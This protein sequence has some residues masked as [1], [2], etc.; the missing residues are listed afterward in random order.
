MF[1]FKL[2]LSL[3]LVAFFVVWTRLFYWQV[4]SSANLRALAEAQH[5]FRL[6]IPARQGKI[7]ATDGM[8][9]ATNQPAYLVFAEKN[10]ITDLPLFIE[11]LAQTLDVDTASLSAKFTGNNLWVP[12]Q[13][14]TEEETVRKL[15][16]LNLKGLDFERD[17]KRY[18]PEA[19]MSAHLLGFVGKDELGHDKGYFGVEGYYEKELR[20]EVGYLRQERDARGAPIVIGENERVEPENGRDL[21]LY[22]DKTIQFIAEDKLQKALTRYGAKSGNVVIM[23]P[24]TGGILASASY[25]S[26]DPAS[27]WQFPSEYYRNPVIAESYEPGSTFKVLVMAKAL[28]EGAVKPHDVYNENGPVEIGEYSI[29]TWNN[30]YHGEISMTE[31]LEYSS[32]VG[33]VDVARKLGREK[34]LQG[35]RDFGFGD[36]TGIDLQEESAPA[37]RDAKEMY[38]IDWATLSFGQGIA[39]TPIQMLRAVAAIAN[40][41]LL[42]QPQVVKRINA[43]GKVVEITPKKIRRVIKSA[44]AKVV[45]EMMVAAVEHG[46]AKWALPKGFRIAGKTGTAQI[47]VA[48]HY[49]AEK[50]IASFVGFAP[51]EEP[52][53]VMLVTLTEPQTSPWGSETAAPLFF[54]ITKELF[55][56]FGLSPKP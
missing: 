27:Y 6:E 24:K 21:V 48:G 53:F 18:Y 38:E 22:L 29:K 36:K 26:Y 13:Q 33:M 19:S 11:K 3:F 43:E 14:K 17:D 44:S 2:L 23:D 52:K 46:E 56:Y 10:K 45:T 30:E 28:D 34:L 51:A 42:M 20:G 9:L 47:P 5:F 8:P 39:V 49:D 7:L 50:T 40:D 35:V 55:T 12:I 15:R 31:I 4:L 16:G 41:G 54:E 37:L 25:P 32:N 1:R